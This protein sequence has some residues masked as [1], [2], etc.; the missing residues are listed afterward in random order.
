[1]MTKEHQVNVNDILGLSTSE[2]PDAVP[3]QRTA[4][5]PGFSKTAQTIIS[6]PWL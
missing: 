2:F 3:A 4:V 5:M 6:T 1:M